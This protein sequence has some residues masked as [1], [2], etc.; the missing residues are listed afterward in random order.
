ME[1]RHLRYFVV[2]AE[3]LHFTRAA[4]RLNIEQSPLSR[5]IRDLEEELGSLLFDRDR[6]GTRLTA[7]GEAFLDDVRRVL[8][9][10]D[11]ACSSVKAISA[12]FRGSLRIAVSDGVVDPRLSAFLARC[13]LEEPEIEIRLI[14]VPLADQVRGLRSGDFHL[15]FAHVQDVGR[16][17]LAEPLWRDSL[18][19]AMPALHPLL[20]H[21]AV[22]LDALVPYRLVMCDPRTCEGCSRELNRLLSTAKC[23]WDVT[24][25][26]SSMDMMLT[27]VAA[28]YGVGFAVA[29]KAAACIRTDIVFRPLAIEAAALTTYMLRLNSETIPPAVVRF[30]SRLHTH[31]EDGK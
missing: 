24:A 25:H 30:T 9:S 4:E 20:E 23:D 11:Q 7:A 28:G 6:R 12:G 17:I 18:M 26:V 1:L 21:A 13:R 5:I 19:L 3:E 10:L 16:D 27:L 8:S 2:L 31:L 15:G 22:P 29:A 14:E